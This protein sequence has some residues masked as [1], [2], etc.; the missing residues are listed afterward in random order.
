MMAILQ[1]FWDSVSDIY[2][3][4][5]PQFREREVESGGLD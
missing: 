1:D 5:V 2:I 4:G 3:I